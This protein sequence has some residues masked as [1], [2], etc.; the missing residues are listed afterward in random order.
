MFNKI[1]VGLLAVAIACM[2]AA[3]GYAFG[4]HLAK[5]TGKTPTSAETARPTA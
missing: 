5:V 2:I 3:S 1:L 4:R